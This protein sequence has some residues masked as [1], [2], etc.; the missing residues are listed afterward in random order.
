MALGRVKEFTA[1][2]SPNPIPPLLPCPGQYDKIGRIPPNSK[3]LPWDRKNSGELKS[4]V[5]TFLRPHK[6]LICLTLLV[7]LMGTV[8][9]W[10]E[11]QDGGH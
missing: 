1:F 3:L 2:F 4:S 7:V 6:E 10:F 11:Y 8:V 9:A 5:L